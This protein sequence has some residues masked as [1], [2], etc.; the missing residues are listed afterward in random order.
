MFKKKGY[1]I[2]NYSFSVV[3]VI[4]S[5]LSISCF[6]LYRLQGEQ[7]LVLKQLLGGMLGVVAAAL[8]ELFNCELHLDD[9]LSIPLAVGAGFL[10][11]TLFV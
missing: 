3:F 11:G 6:V 5:L 4:L 9:N 7:N 8:L 10:L 1:S 2:S